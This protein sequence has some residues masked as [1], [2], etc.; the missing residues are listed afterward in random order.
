MYRR[1]YPDVPGLFDARFS[2]YNRPSLWRELQSSWFPSLVGFCLVIAGCSL[3]LWN[4]ARAVRMSLA[5]EEGLRDV[6]VPE[7]LS[8]VFEE[9]NGKLVLI[10]GPLDVPDALVDEKYGI[11]IKA[12]KLRKVVQVYQWFET[13]DQKS[14]EANEIS[15]NHNHEKT[16]SYDTDWYEYHIDSSNFANTLGHHNP[17]LDEWPLNSSSISNSRVKIGGYLLGT[18]IKKMFTTF[19]PFTSDARPRIEGVRI[20][21]GLYYHSANLWQP[22]VG[23]YRVQ[24]S[25]SG[26]AGDEFTVVGRQAGREVRPY[27][28]EGGEELL[29]LQDGIRS[30]AEVFRTEQNNNRTQTWLY[31]LGGWLAMFLGLTLLSQVL[32]LALDLVPR[33][34]QVLALQIGSLPFSVSLTLT[35]GIIGL[36]WLLFRPLLGFA[37]LLLAAAPYFVP[38]YRLLMDRRRI[39]HRP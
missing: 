20:Y 34:R 22:E 7:T 35:L 36:G 6:T 27:K 28:T 25:Y 24:F 8:V 5:L 17:H 14:A 31:R 11:S 15:D 32:E 38:F 10:S 29:I 16:Y 13:E 12:A 3:L 21:A 2:E 23:D 1:E 9:N 37:L 26:R 33:L 4:E 39:S 30:P 18:D 19:T